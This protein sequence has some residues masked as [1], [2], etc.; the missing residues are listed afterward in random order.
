M[1]IVRLWIIHAFIVYYPY[2]IL[3]IIHFS[4]NTVS[5]IINFYSIA[6]FPKILLLYFLFFS[7]YVHSTPFGF[8]HLAIMIWQFFS[9]H[10]M[11]FCILA[12]EVPAFL[13]GRVSIEHPRELYSK[14][15]SSDGNMN[16]F[17]CEWS[18]FYPLNSRYIPIEDRNEWGW[19]GGYV[20]TFYRKINGTKITFF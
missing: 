16:A 2:I 10:A 15:Q 13:R 12:Y 8:F 4:S 18:L 11:A 3:F 9:V 6:F 19:F 14:I 20:H 1:S 17:S 5:Q 7:I